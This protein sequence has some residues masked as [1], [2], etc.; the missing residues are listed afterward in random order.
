[1]S[2]I[3][4]HI[5]SETNYKPPKTIWEVQK[6]LKFD[7]PLE[8]YRSPLCRYATSAWGIQF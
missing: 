6:E 7:L 4:F 2:D 8:G 1:M 5:Q 3:E